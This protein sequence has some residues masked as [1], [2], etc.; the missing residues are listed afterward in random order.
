MRG[1]K[2]GQEPNSAREV[3]L[4]VGLRGENT[5]GQPILMVNKCEEFCEVVCF[6]L[7]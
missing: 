4:N 5:F 3:K 6:C 7:N 1:G 2:I